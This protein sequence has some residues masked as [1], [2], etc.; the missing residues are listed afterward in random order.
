MERE[1][2]RN[3]L[4]E[5]ALVF[6]RC[7]SGKPRT[8]MEVAVEEVSARLCADFAIEVVGTLDPW[9][10]VDE[11][12]P[13]DNKR[14]W[15]TFISEDGEVGIA[16]AYRTSPEHPWADWETGDFFNRGEIIAWQTFFVPPPFAP[17]D[18]GGE[19]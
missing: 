16:S 3:D 8:A 18:K 9:V 1:K 12:L 15:V 17:A 14:K 2:L 11:R 13:T 10:S 5:R 7:L 19:K 4:I 6:V